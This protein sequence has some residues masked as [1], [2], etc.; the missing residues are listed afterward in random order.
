MKTPTVSYSARAFTLLEL[1]ICAGLVGILFILL[2]S[3]IVF[4]CRSSDPYKGKLVRALS[5][6]KQLQLATQQL[7]L[8]GISTGDA[9]PDWTCL[10]GKPIT[11]DE[12]RDYLIRGNYLTSSDFSRFTS[13]T[14]SGFFGFSEEITTA[15]QVYAVDAT[16]PDTTVLLTT[17]NWL[18]PAAPELSDQPFKKRGFV[19][20]RKNGSGAI[21]QPRQLNQTDI[22]GSGGKLNYLPLQ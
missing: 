2:F 4:G 6:M 14:K 20:I 19:V 10:R 15:I 9:Q 5:N 16:D 22:I 3:P 7:A 8:D 21:L 11:Y 12:W 17:K 1:I 18:G 13:V